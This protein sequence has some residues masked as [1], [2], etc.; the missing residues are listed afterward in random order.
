[1]CSTATYGVLTARKTVVTEG[2]GDNQKETITQDTQVGGTYERT[3]VHTEV[4]RVPEIYAIDVARPFAGSIDYEIEMAPGLAYPSRLKGKV[5]DKTLEILRDA[6]A[7]VLDQLK[8]AAGAPTAGKVAE[9][10]QV[11]RLKEAIDR[12]EIR[13]LATLELITTF[14]P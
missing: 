2:V 6:L 7:Q 11:V 8:G 4:V 13:D 3:E 5:E 9:E 14:K 12:V 10:A 1:T